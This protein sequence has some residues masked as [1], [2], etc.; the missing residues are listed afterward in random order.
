[1][2]SSA[3]TPHAPTHAAP[4]AQ[5]S[6][7]D[8]FV[9]PLT[10]RNASREMTEI[11]CPRHRFSTWRRV[12][13][14]VA[15][16][17]HE[18]G[19]SVTR[20]Q[21]EAIRAHQGISDDEIRRAVE[22]ERK[23]KHDV[24]SHVHAL[25]EVAPAAKGIIH[26]GM[27]SQ[28]VTCNADLI[29]IKEALKL[30]E[31]KIA[32][33]IDAIGTFAEKWRDTPVL[34]LTHYQA[35]Q[36]TTVGRRAAGWGYDLSIMLTR[37]ES[38]VGHMKLRGLK[39][40]TGTQASFMALLENNISKVEQLEQSFVRKLGWPGNLV[41]DLAWQTYPR[42]VDALVVSDLAAVAAVC[43]KICTDIRLSAGRK[44]LDEPFGDSQVGSSAMP[45]KQNPMRCERACG[46]ARF[47]MGLAQD[48]LETAALQWFERTLDDSSNRRI[49]LPESFL[50]LD[51]VLDLVHSVFSGLVVHTSQTR[52]ALQTEL[53]F[54]VLENIL[55]AAV[56]AGKDRQEVHEVLRR[57]A[58]AAARRVKDQALPNDLA[59]RLQSEPALH[60]VR[61]DNLLDPLHYVGRA[62]EQVDKFLIDIVASVRK[63]YGTQYSVL[64][65]S[66][67]RV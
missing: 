5:E 2:P 36:P 59:E 27:T 63:G 53:P 26:L 1:M 34:G 16:A 29:M 62:R 55:M 61:L 33:V 31:L 37:L 6:F 39:G 11:W 3:N 46:L 14:A 15:E 43:H 40:A 18:L 20:E 22:H 7:Y 66:E 60:G 35:A 64:S 58:L 10:Q 50:A 52:A 30:I 32:R 47:V 23:I 51:G 67:P 38:T 19:M 8:T 9:S 65:S 24:M 44:E 28:D 41:H 48:P 25:G 54:L 45:Y 56:K 13:L 21:V 4:I 17:Q 12:W 42:I 57:H 49:V